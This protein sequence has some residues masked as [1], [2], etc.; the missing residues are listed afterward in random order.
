VLAFDSDLAPIVGQQVSAT[1]TTLN[2]PAVVA[3]IALDQDEANRCELV[4]KG[5]L[6]G[7][8]RGW[9]YDDAI[10]A[11]CSDRVAD[12]SISGAT[13]RG[14]AAT[15]GQPRTYT[16]VPLGSGLRV[17]VDRDEDGFLDSDEIDAG[18]DPAD[19]AST[20]GGEVPATLVRGGKLLLRD[21]STAPINLG[22]RKVRFKT[23]AHG[24]VASG[25]VP[26]LPGS[27]GDP[28]ASGTT[29]GAT[30]TV[31]NANGSG[32]KVVVNLP[33]SHWQALG[34]GGN[35]G[36]SIATRMRSASLGRSPPSSSTRAAP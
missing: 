10:D 2:D 34:S 31:Y 32:E 26:M 21:D 6:A 33:E 14:Q 5:V 4:V 9:L 28:T 1:A 27:T 23:G 36:G 22:K 7:E 13:L 3:R 16:C 12:A 35:P 11:F 25:V 19:A 17:G 20:P 24:G 29:G 8:M 30:L 18:S 15:S